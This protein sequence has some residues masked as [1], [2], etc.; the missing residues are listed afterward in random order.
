MTLNIFCSCLH[1][2]VPGLQ[3]FGN[4]PSLCGAEEE[5]QGFT[6][7]GARLMWLMSGPKGMPILKTT[8][9]VPMSASD[10]LGPTEA[11]L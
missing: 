7:E 3:D 8:K 6:H 10:S 4:L 11:R 2:P 1:L 5:A 9:A